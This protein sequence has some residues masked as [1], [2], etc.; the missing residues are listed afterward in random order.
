[1]PLVAFNFKTYNFFHICATSSKYM[2]YFFKPFLHI[3]CYTC[4]VVSPTPRQLGKAVTLLEPITS[5]IVSVMAGVICHLICKWLDE[6][7]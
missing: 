7:D 2:F 1:M 3:S 6:N 5:L 4:F